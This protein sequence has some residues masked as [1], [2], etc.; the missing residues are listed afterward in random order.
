MQHFYEHLPPLNADT[1]HYYTRGCNAAN[2]C[3]TAKSLSFEA[4]KVVQG[5]GIA[6]AIVIGCDALL[7]EWD[8]LIYKQDWCHP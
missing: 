7:R 1:H 3:Y 5:Q 8:S 4:D 2:N 6:C